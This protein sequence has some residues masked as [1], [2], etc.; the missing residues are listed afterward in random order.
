MSLWR[1]CVRLGLA[2]LLLYAGAVKIV[3]P[4]SFVGDLDHYR[5]LS[6]ALA[7]LVALG[8]PV[9][10]VVA[11]VGLLLPGYA[12]A[13]ALLSASMLLGFGAAMTQ[14]KLRGINLACGCFGAGSDLQVS[15]G[16]VTLDLALAM[17]AGWLAFAP[18]SAP[19]RPLAEQA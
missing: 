11:G 3:D 7:P 17:L 19:S 10:E 14:A 1:L 9:L 18:K 5:V 15:W 2:G 6:Q 8:L 16:K 13:G 4:G 12:Q